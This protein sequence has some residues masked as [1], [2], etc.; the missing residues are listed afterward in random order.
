M[1]CQKPYL[2]WY[3]ELNQYLPFGCGRCYACRVK[4][5]SQWAVRMQL[6]ALDYN[7]DELHFVTLTY[8]DENLPKNR[9]LSPRDVQLFW[10]RLRKNLDYKIRY[11]LCGEYGDKTFRPHYHAIICG[12]KKEDTHLVHKA[13]GLGIT[14][15]KPA[16]TGSFYYVSG[17]VTK[18]LGAVKDWKTKYPNLVPPFM[19]CSL[20]FGKSFVDKATSYSHLLRIGSKDVYIGRYLRNKLAEKFGITELVKNDG[21]TKLYDQ[22]M[23]TIDIFKGKFE[24]DSMSKTPVKDLTEF[25]YNM[26][27]Q[28]DFDLQNAKIRLNFRGDCNDRPPIKNTFNE[29]TDRSYRNTG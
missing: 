18:K 7:Q 28:G 1:V 15:V 24:P 13:W 19:R 4:N 6:E 11:W 23:E 5:A 27:Y 29:A 25:C 9:S 17:Y 16:Y 12:L 21:L 2:K 14:E 8:A 22:I 3:S 10:K 20:G 26:R